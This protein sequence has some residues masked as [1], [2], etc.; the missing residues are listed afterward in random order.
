VRLSRLAEVVSKEFR[1]L[2]R[3]RRIY[4]IVLIAPIFQLFLYGFAATLDLHELP[5]AVLDADRSSESR[6]ILRALETSG[7]FRVAHR[8]ESYREIEALLERG[9]IRIA[10]AIPPRFGARLREAEEASARAPA[11]LS[12]LVDGSNSNTA[13]IARSSLQ[14]VIGRRALDRVVGRAREREMG[15]AMLLDRLESPDGLPEAIEVRTR[16]LYNPELRSRC[17]MVPGVIV[18]ILLVMTMVFSALAIVKEKE[19]GTFEMLRA[20]PL[21]PVELVAG[22]LIPFVLIG[23]LDVL[24]VLGAAAAIFDVPV[25]GS[26]GLLLAFAGAFVLTT[27]GLGLLVSAFVGSQQQAMVVSFVLLLPMVLLSGFIFPI[28][29]MPRPAQIASYALPIRYFIAAVRAIFLRGVGLDV[30][31]PEM[32]ALLGLGTAILAAAILR[33][34]KRAL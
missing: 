19:L 33:F 5:I 26:V 11:R 17:Y 14:A 4:P 34:G 18:L 29:S 6:A 9:D 8:V 31:L 3:D 7:E 21:R 28:E 13:T 23:F 16:V 1:Q 30:L 27:I 22:K 12:V 32:L 15:A 20:T 25:R 2:S 10:I 24:I